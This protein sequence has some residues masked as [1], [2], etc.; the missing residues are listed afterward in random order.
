[1]Y[2]IEEIEKMICEKHKILEEKQRQLADWAKITDR[3]IWEIF[4]LWIITITTASVW[5]AADYILYGSVQ[6]RFMDEII[7]MVISA[8]IWA[9][10]F[11]IRNIYR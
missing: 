5:C 9:A 7:C 2:E 6:N 4:R 10:D 11:L 8:G 3:M 1:M